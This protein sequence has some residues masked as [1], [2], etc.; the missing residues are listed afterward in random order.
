MKD[1]LFQLRR[2]NELHKEETRRVIERHTLVVRDMNSA[3]ADELSACES[4]IRDL[5]ISLRKK[6][7]FLLAFID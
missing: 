4:K 3:H 1:S 6:N 7:H 2:E 5:E